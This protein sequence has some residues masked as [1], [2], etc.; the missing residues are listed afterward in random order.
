MKI[1][2]V[3]FD[4]D[5]LLIDSEPLWHEAAIEAMAPFDISMTN[6]EYASSIGLRT[7]EFLAYWFRHYGIDS[8]YAGQTEQE[9]NR[10]VIEKVKEKGEALPG[11]D[12]IFDFFSGKDFNIGIATSSPFSLIDVVTEKLGIK[13]YLHAITSA[14]KLYLGKPHPEVYLNCAEKL[15]V[16][17]VQCICFEDSFN[18]LIAAKAAR[19]KCIV[20]PAPH[21]RHEGKWDAADLKLV[22]LAEFSEEVLHQLN[23]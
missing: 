21:V 14:E 17:P 5:G 6:E 13:K 23:N 8:K 15:N 3:I 1:N 9:I 16:Q 7:K 4:M 12:Y 11:V 22:S 18:G 19:M 10:I 20:V 2:T